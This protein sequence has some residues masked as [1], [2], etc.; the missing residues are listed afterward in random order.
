M[1]IT[2]TFLD[3]ISFDIPHQNWGYTE[4]DNDFTAM[5]TMGIKRV[6]MIRCAAGNF[7]TYNSKIIPKFSG[8]PMHCPPTDLVD[9]FL[10]LAEKHGMEFFFGTYHCHS[11]NC[12]NWNDPE[13][14][15]NEAKVNVEIISE[16]QE[17]YGHRKAFKGWYLT[18]EICAN[19]SGTIDF[20]IEQAQHAKK[21][22]NNKPTLISPYFAGI[23]AHGGPGFDPTYRPL[24]IEEH[25][26]DWDKIFSQLSG[27]LDFVAFQDGHVNYDELASYHKATRILA[28]RYGIECWSNIESF[29]RDM[30]INFLPIKWEKLLWKM[31]AAQDA[32]IKEGITFEFSH[33]MSPNSMYQSAKGLYDRYCEHYGI[34]T[35]KDFK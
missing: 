21:I 6:I 29:D 25:T 4:W 20:F 9:L 30:P 8:K 11:G 19:N 15:R 13:I 28:E 32:G 18:H 31:E 12:R 26:A 10:E 1:R 23:K 24:T 14:F 35:V 27:S 33:F 3:E 16:V 22:S 34:Q 5:K 17:L 2:G 7:M